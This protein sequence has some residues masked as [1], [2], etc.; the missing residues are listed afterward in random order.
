MLDYASAGTARVRVEAILPG[1]G[2]P[3]P[4]LA[5]GAMQPAAVSIAPAITSSP[6]PADDVLPS[7]GE[8]LQIGAYASEESARSLIPRLASITSLPVVIH[9]EPQAGTGNLLH[10]VR[11]GPLLDGID[12]NSLIRSIQNA[13]LGNPF[14]VTQ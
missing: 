6:L 2:Q 11:V 8:Y 13:N 7:T 1:V 12:V 10:R 4:V 14:R 3:A 9:A 5:S